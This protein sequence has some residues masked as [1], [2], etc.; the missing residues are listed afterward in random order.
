MTTKVLFIEP[1]KDYWF[2]MGEY[3]PP[4]TP[5][6]ALAAYMERELDDVEVGLLDCQAESVDWAG[7]EERIR[8]FAPDVVALS[9]FTCNAY[10]C[11]RTAESAKIVDPDIV[12][13]VGGQHFSFTADESLRS[14]PEIDYVVRGEGER[15]L[16]ELLRTLRTGGDLR[17][18]DGLSF[19]HEGSMI[20]NPPRNMIE[21][22]DSLPYPA[23]HLIEKNIDRYHFRMM[24]GKARYLIIEGSR[25]CWHRCSFCTQWRH[26]GGMWRTKS[27][28]RI[29]DEMVY[30]RD[31][32][33]GRFIWLTDDNFELGKRGLDLAMELKEREFGDS[34][35][36]FFQA[37]M[38]DIVQHP[39]VVSRLHDV[40]N[41]WQ[42]FGV[43][44]GS[45]QV[46]SAFRKGEK[47]E[48]AAR[49]VEVLRKNG[50]LAQA[51]MV[52]G[53]RSDTH[54]S[55][56]QLREF[57][58]GLD[59]DLAIFSILTPLP[60]TEVHEAAARNGWIEDTNY[61]HYDMVHAIM[62]TEALTRQDVQEELYHCYR[63]F[64]GSP[65]NV[66]RGLFSSNELKK[67]GYRHLA[68]K[69]VLGSLR[70]LI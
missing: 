34:T 50:V 46:L 38:D 7:V 42:L 41:S 18:V 3:L 68:G 1:P 52:T 9:G 20:H 64:F 21:D 36:W 23:Y 10:V 29:A 40:G 48:D 58:Q 16:V 44:N 11:A 59:P 14:F 25:G 69:R 37:R 8:A 54:E 2:L 62:P 27:A 26:W 60:G 39:Q 32:L 28:R 22:L 35:T 30:L 47:V 57:T 15:T 33:G 5:L 13:V 49:A 4:P 66:V 55:I 51:M 70:Q 6:L 19:R 65:M 24:G 63:S 56:E 31:E 45:P 67:R 12:T 53:S 43:E 17:S 61:S